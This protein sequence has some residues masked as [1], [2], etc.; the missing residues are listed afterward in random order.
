MNDFLH[1]LTAY[2]LSF[3]YRKRN[4]PL[5]EQLSEQIK[6]D[7]IPAI[8]IEE[9]LNEFKDL[10]SNSKFEILMNGGRVVL[11][12]SIKDCEE[13]KADCK[14]Y[15]C[16]VRAGKTNIPIK[17]IKLA[18]GKKEYDFDA[19]WASTY[20]HNIFIYD[21]NGDYYMVCHRNG[22][23]GCKTVLESV[24]NKILMAKGMKIDMNWIPPMIDESQS[25]YDI[26]K[27][28]LIYEE[29]KSSDI[30]DEVN[31]NVKKIQVKELTL[32]LSG[33]KFPLISNSLK[34]YQLK[35]IT[36]EQALNEIKNELNDNSYNNA[37]V[38]VKIG[39]AKKKVAWN[40]LEGLI[41]GFDITDRVKGLKGNAF[42]A[43]LKNASDGFISLLI[44]KGK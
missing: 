44:N 28:S 13:I 10:S 1:T 25:H 41:D 15:F 43:A 40:D 2:H 23:S 19:D 18:N 21:F 37:S 35:E 30:A 5:R 6:N 34:R 3:S 8:R 4:N 7:E 42:V 36:R 38:F 20:P 9:V 14:R 39:K 24:L 27:I 17:M 12:D 33:G 29:P 31:K 32:S 11:L 22:G 16:I 26:E